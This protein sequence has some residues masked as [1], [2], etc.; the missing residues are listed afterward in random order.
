MLKYNL[1]TVCVNLFTSKTLY[2]SQTKWLH[3][4]IQHLM[5]LT[6]LENE[7]VVLILL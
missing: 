6:L 2:G 4:I 5:L 7:S 1:E 3:K